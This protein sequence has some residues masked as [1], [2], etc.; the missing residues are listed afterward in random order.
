[1]R[2]FKRRRY[3]AAR[4]PAILTVAALVSATSASA[5]TYY[6]DYVLTDRVYDFDT[7]TN[8]TSVDPDGP[9]AAYLTGQVVTSGFGTLDDVLLSWSFTM[10]DKNTL[11]TISS[12]GL[13]AGSLGQVRESRMFRLSATDTGLFSLGGSWTFNEEVQ[14]IDDFFVGFVTSDL[15]N[16]RFSNVRLNVPGQSGRFGTSAADY[17]YFD[18]QDPVL[19]GSITPPSTIDPISAVPLPAGLPLL[20]AGLG[21]L[22]LLRRRQKAR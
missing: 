14:V 15:G 13:L 9:E 4:L 8:Q 22:G 1:M 21:A 19:F 10:Q 11:T 3:S 12:D 7:E 17:D 18:S 2:Q 20:A 6:I 5:A 16:L